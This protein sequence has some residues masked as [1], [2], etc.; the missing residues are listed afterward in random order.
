MVYYKRTGVFGERDRLLRE[1]V[2]ESRCA[3]RWA[4]IFYA[5]HIDPLIDYVTSCS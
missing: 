3:H 2:R 4:E 5:R 1:L